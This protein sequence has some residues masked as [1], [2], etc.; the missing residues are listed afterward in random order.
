MKNQGFAE[1]LDMHQTESNLC[2]TQDPALKFSKLSK[3][4][5]QISQLV[6]PLKVRFHKYAETLSLS[7]DK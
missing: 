3:I 6:C 7:E 4:W 5:K 2:L 1:T